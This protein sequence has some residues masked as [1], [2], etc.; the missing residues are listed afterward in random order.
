MNKIKRMKIILSPDVFKMIFFIV[1]ILGVMPFLSGEIESF[2]KL[3]HVYAAAV[4]VNDLLGEKRLI[5]NKG[6]IFLLMFIIS[7][8]VTLCNNTNLIN[9]SGISNFCYLLINLGIVYS[10]G[11]DSEKFDKITSNIVC[12]LITVANAIGIGMFYAKTYVY[13]EHRGYLGMY[14]AENRLSGLFGNPNVL[15]MICLIGISLSF[16]LYLQNREEKYRYVYV[17]S[18]VVNFITLLLSNSRTQL[19]S[20]IFL[21]ATFFALRVLKDGITAKK[22]MKACVIG[23]VVVSVGYCGSKLVQKGLSMLDTNYQ[24]YYLYIDEEHRINKDEDSNG[25]LAGNHSSNGHTR[26]NKKPINGDMTSTIDRESS[27]FNGRL[28]LWMVGKDLFLAKPLFGHGLDNHDYALYLLNLPA[29]PVKGNLHNVYI[30]LIVACGLGGLFC[31]MMFLIV[32]AKRTLKLVKKGAFEKNVQGMLLLV[33]VAAFMLDGLVDST[34]IA[35]VYPTSVAF[36]FIMSCYVRNLEHVQV[37]GDKL[38]VIH[39]VSK[40]DRAG[41][42]TFIMNLF[43]K[44][45]KDKMQF[46]FLCTD[47]SPADYDEEIRALGGNIYYVRP[48]KMAGPLKQIEKFLALVSALSKMEGEYVFHIHTH[49]A[50][51]AVSNVFAAKVAGVR[52]IVIH[53]HNTSALYHL[54][55]HALF[56]KVLNLLEIRRFA[57]SYEAG[58]WMFEKDNFEVLHNGIDMEVFRFNTETRN[59]VRKDLGWGDK[60]IVGHIGRFNEQKNHTFMVE[61]F[62]KIYEQIKDAQLVLVGKGELEDQVREKIRKLGIEEAVTFLGVRDDVYRLYQGMDLFLFPSLFEG[63]PVVLVEAQ[64]GDLPCLISDTISREVILTDRVSIARLDAD[65]QEWADQ[66][67]SVIKNN[68]KRKDNSEEIKAARYDIE[69][70]AK[71][72]RKYYLNEREM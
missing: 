53:S 55:A 23:L 71:S 50:M 64:G 33:I 8:G 3:F 13:Y 15:G 62:A 5:N 69:D 27:G 31:L 35:S 37:Y 28:D 48:I 25:Q 59:K 66:A 57:C 19:Y 65:A 70:L 7:Y 60:I 56:K 12:G 36:W 11:K 14:P 41:Q 4:V 44:I 54:K 6:R 24:Y 39:F 61:I 2:Y 34:L 45:D 42:E 1:S 22:F 38:K 52:T 26:P 72:L 10:Y 18:A 20:V 68:R 43:R 58:K 17:L 46:D 16:L 63:L 49:H 40:M 67:I 29:L 30:D 51:D 32:I 47:N 9:F 21:C